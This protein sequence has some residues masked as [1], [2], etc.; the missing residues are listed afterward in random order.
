MRNYFTLSFMQRL[1]GLLILSILISPSLC[2]QLPEE[3]HFVKGPLNSVR[4]EREGKRVAIYGGGAPEADFVLMTHLRSDVTEFARFA[5][6]ESGGIVAPRAVADFLADPAKHWDAWWLKRFDYYDQQVT[7][8]PTGA[9]EVSLPVADGDIVEGPGGLTFRVLETPG[10]TREGVTYLTEIAGKK[11]AFTGDLILAGGRVPD[12]YSF[13][14]AIPEAKIGGYHGYGGRLG[15][16]VKSLE[17]LA[18]EKP[19]MLVPIHG[20]LVFE[21]QKD[22]NSLIDRVRKIYFNY[23]STNALNWYFKEE[24]LTAAGRLVLGEG[25]EVELMDYSEHIDLPDWC[26]HLGTT[27]LLL[28]DDGSGFALDCGGKGPLEELRK[29]LASGIMTRVDGIFVTHTHND[30]TAAVA[31]AAREFGC[32]VYAVAEVADA[33]LH[34]GAWFLPGLS[35]NAV[36][37]VTT[38][39]DGEVLPWKNYRL[40]AQFFPG[41]MYNHGALLVDRKDHAPVFFIGDSFSPSG[42]D[43]YCLMNRNLMREDTGFFLCLRKLRALPEGSWM[44]NQHI[45]HLFRFSNE[46][47]DLLEKRYAERRDMIAD[48][49]PWDDPNFAIDERWASFYPYGQELKVGQSGALELQLWNHSTREREVRVSLHLPEGLSAEKA[50]AAV[51]IPARGRG[52]VVFAIAVAAGASPGVNVITADLASDDLALQRWA[53]ALVKVP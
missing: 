3:V 18:A 52:K 4:I 11:I 7:R 8:L 40:T 38:L 50:E 34:P 23:L 48:L 53:E 12:L 47:L 44:V 9:L 6:G 31:E 22:I 20:E 5:K 42:I 41:Q 43:D 45:P 32:P 46:R 25:A 30:H 10:Y 2:A 24:R 28:A 14:E 33:L 27:K 1:F 35:P 13:Q 36:D 51:K 26:K 16:L 15:Q 19:D 21:P 29:A 49:T 39:A 37:H 17:K